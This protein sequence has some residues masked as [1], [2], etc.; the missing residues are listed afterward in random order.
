MS[1]SLI[2]CTIA[3]HLLIG[4]WHAM[5]VILHH[6]QWQPAQWLDWEAPKHFPKPNVH[7][8]QS[9]SLLGALLPLWSTTAFWILAK[10]LHLRSML[11]KSMR[12]TENCNA[13]SQYWSTRMAQF[14]ST[15]TPNLKSHNQHFKS[16][17]NWATKFC[18]I[19][20]IHLISRW[21]TTTSP[22]ILT[23]LCRKNASTTR[24]CFPRIAQILK[25]RLLCYRNKWTYF[26]SAKNVLI[27]TILILI[28]KDVFGPNYNDLKF[29]V[30][31]HYYVFIKLNS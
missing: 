16:W 8:K 3:N 4:L 6:C 1:S 22:S 27:V 23:I 7:Q 10:P 2:L 5:I 19:C 11:S 17:R 12:C 31:N 15:T 14:F 28:N 9:W 20:H 13:C 26:L 18:L 30:Q 29:T 25:H 21:P 24:K